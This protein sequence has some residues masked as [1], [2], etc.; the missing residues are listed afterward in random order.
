MRVTVLNNT[1]H[2]SRCFL[3][4]FLISFF[5]SLLP[6]CSQLA[7]A[8]SDTGNANDLQAALPSIPGMLPPLP[9][10]GGSSAEPGRES[11]SRISPRVWTVP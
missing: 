4:L 11:G 1:L 2:L 9:G 8:G 3:S 6:N 10:V 5:S 7:A